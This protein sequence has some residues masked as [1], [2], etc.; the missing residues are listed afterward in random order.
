[1]S[2]VKMCKNLDKVDIKQEDLTFAL[3]KLLIL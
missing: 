1:M 3:I 2:S